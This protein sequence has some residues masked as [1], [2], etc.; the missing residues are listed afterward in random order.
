M[1]KEKE[2]R[3]GCF[4]TILAVLLFIVLGVAVLIGVNIQKLKA[5]HYDLKISGD[6]DDFLSGMEK[7]K[8][9][10]VGDVSRLHLL[11][12]YNG[13]YETD[14]SI[15]VEATLSVEEIYAILNEANKESGPLK[16]IQIKL[17]QGNRFE[18]YCM[19][20]KSIM[21]VMN[22]HLGL[23]EEENPVLV[24]WIGKI[25]HN[26]PVY[27]KGSFELVVTKVSGIKPGMKDKEIFD[28]TVRSVERSCS[29]LCLDT[30]PIVLLHSFVEWKNGG[31][32]A[33]E[34]LEYLKDRGYIKLAG[35]SL[36]GSDDTD[37][38]LEEPVFDAVQV[39]VNIFD[40]RLVR[41]GALERLRQ[42]GMIVFVRSIYLQ[43][44]LFLEPE[45]LSGK[46]TQ[47]KPYIEKLRA[48]CSKEQRSIAE[49]ALAYVRDQEAVTG[50]V[51]G[52]ETIEQVRKNIELY[53]TPPLSKEMTEEIMDCFQ[54][55]P[56]EVTDPRTW[57]K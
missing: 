5:D 48:L 15:P 22:K 19:T 57:G 10:V 42:K 46:L 28:Y 49:T 9:D 37:R 16:N 33:V 31:K 12:I 40:L 13:D 23:T 25:L 41:S 24:K 14:G 51:L 2:K 54:S 39:P 32:A 7:V 52:C 29:L 44:L 8:T 21:T 6:Y 27:G 38:V 17:A 26:K 56:D 50:L 4:K 45:E 34:A 35:I 1:A 55:V 18:F 43:G 47:A 11:N 36:Y 3:G 30:I 20:N 53:H